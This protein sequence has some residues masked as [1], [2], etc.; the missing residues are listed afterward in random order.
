MRK[1]VIGLAGFALLLMSGAPRAAPP[2]DPLIVYAAGSTRGALAAALAAYEKRTGVHV[3]LQ[4]GPAGLMLERIEAGEPA[5]LFVS[6]NRAFPERLAKEG[7]GA[8]V[9]LFA[10]NSLC[11]RALPAV[12]LTSMN[13]MDRMLD[14]RFAIGTST[15]KVD[16][17]GD[18]AWALFERIDRLRP[19][20]GAVLKAKAKIIS[21]GRTPAVTPAP[22]SAAAAMQE[23]GVD[24][25]IGYCSITSADADTGIDR[26]AVPVELVEPIDYGMTVLASPSDARRHAAA[27]ALE[28]ALEGGE[29]QRII[30]DFGFSSAR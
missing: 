5:D 12:G 10:R 19:G 30:S 21:G 20:S 24:M 15:P 27:L 3:S 29:A 1:R 16:P 6:A 25:T 18:Y 23:K 22:T 4:T 9:R 13:L 28:Q 2:G 11:V 14:P 8:P 26:V 17:A 7:K